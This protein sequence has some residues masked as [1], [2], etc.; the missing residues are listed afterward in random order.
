MKAVLCGQ[1]MESEMRRDADKLQEELLRRMDMAIRAKS[2]PELA[3]AIRVR[4]EA[5]DRARKRKAEQ[6]RDDYIR[7][8]HAH[9]FLLDRALK[10]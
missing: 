6:D 9:G 2:D 1:L 3:E 10:G 7:E 4:E 8:C 5:E